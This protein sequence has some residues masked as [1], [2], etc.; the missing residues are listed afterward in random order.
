MSMFFF[1]RR[2]KS[3]PFSREWKTCEKVRDDFVHIFY[4]IICFLAWK[5][6]E[7][8]THKVYKAIFLYAKKEHRSKKQFRMKKYKISRSIIA[9]W[10]IDIYQDIN[11]EYAI[12][13]V[14][15]KP[16]R[17]VLYLCR[18]QILPMIYKKYYCFA[19]WDHDCYSWRPTTHSYQYQL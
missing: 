7:I 2:S 12:S 10:G 4:V 3:T 15:K 11:I 17:V 13:D 19:R 9:C 5:S 18:E 6:K 1:G 16:P 14:C 8:R